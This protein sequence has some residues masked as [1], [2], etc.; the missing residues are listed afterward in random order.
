M[1]QFNYQR[2][3]AALVDAMFTTDEDAAKKHGVSVRSI[4]RW[5]DRMKE[6]PRLAACVSRLASA[7]EQDWIADIPVAITSGIKFLKRAADE[8]DHR[9]P[10]VIVAVA[11]SLKIL[12]DI[13]TTRKIVDVQLQQFAVIESSTTSEGAYLDEGFAETTIDTGAEEVE[14]D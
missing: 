11:G 7:K 1:P 9:D 4:W 12:S 6:D 2:A 3:A 5:R 10:E 8:A 13:E 14:E